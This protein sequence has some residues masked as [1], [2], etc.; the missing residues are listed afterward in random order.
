[1]SDTATAPTVGRAGAP[2]G[3][4]RVPTRYLVPSLIFSI[5]PLNHADRSCLSIKR[6]RF[7]EP[8]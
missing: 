7:D 4:C 5:T 6:I 1:M 2:T 8:R 3:R